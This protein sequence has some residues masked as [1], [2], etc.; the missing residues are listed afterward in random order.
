MAT[1]ALS[2]PN[3]ANT[4]TVLWAFAHTFSWLIKFIVIVAWL[5]IRCQHFLRLF[6]LYAYFF[7]V[8]FALFRAL[9]CIAFLGEMM[10]SPLE[11]GLPTHIRAAIYLTLSIL[12]WLIWKHAF[13]AVWSRIEVGFFA[14]STTTLITITI[15]RADL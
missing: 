8:A 10:A 11:I 13:R 12:I 7:I 14:G 2:K 15:L 6:A 1:L 3:R 4:L 5:T 9:L